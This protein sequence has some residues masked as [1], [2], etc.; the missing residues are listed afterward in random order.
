MLAFGDIEVDADVAPDRFTVTKDRNAAR[1]DPARAAGLV[2][3]FAFEFK[4]VQRCE[5]ALRADRREG[6]V[7]FG[8]AADQLQ[9]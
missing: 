7:T 2:A 5:R 1:Q 6:R 4:R 3:V 9:I 8:P